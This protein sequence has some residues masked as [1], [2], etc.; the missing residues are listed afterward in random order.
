MEERSPKK[1]P[2]PPIEVG[3]TADEANLTPEQQ[4]AIKRDKI[5]REAAEAE[6]IAKKAYG[7]KPPPWLKNG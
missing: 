7:E 6:G 1:P 4:E 3:A 2:A 5:M